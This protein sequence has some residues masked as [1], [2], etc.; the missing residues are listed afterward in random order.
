MDFF[1]LSVKIECLIWLEH[2]E[3]QENSWDPL[4]S[5]EILFSVTRQHLSAAIPTLPAH[6]PL[7]RQIWSYHGHILEGFSDFPGILE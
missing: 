7:K 1:S 4:Y 2:A 5:M 3:E 6:F